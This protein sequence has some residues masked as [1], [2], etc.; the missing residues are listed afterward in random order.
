ML[1]KLNL[2][3]IIENNANINILKKQTSASIKT[4]STENGKSFLLKSFTTHNLITFA[5]TFQ[6]DFE[7]L[8]SEI[9]SNVFESVD[10]AILKK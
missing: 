7:S 1:H 9:L 4:I 2:S 5:L 6:A 3:K 10:K 8:I